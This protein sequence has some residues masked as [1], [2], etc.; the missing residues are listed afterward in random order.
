MDKVVILLINLFFLSPCILF[1]E[2][3]IYV[4]RRLGRER[5]SSGNQPWVPRLSRLSPSLF[6]SF[7]PSPTSH[8]LE[9]PITHL[10]FST[11]RPQKR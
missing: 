1:I 10:R 5:E 8:S 2:P 11:L 3:F 7:R 4:L 9:N 6:R